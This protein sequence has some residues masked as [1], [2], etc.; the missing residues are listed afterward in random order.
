MTSDCPVG[1]SF[2]GLES[3]SIQKN[4]QAFVLPLA[5]PEV[6]RMNDDTVMAIIFS[7]LIGLP[8]LLC[9][10][11]CWQERAKPT[12]TVIPETMSAQQTGDASDVFSGTD[13]SAPAFTQDGSLGLPPPAVTRQNGGYSLRQ[14]L[15]SSPGSTLL[16]MYM[17]GSDK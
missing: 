5:P 11:A 1:L 3:T 13:T 17:D 2:T 15:S 8:L 12:P 7:L 9:C 6:P 16:P 10:C 14:Q 4:Q